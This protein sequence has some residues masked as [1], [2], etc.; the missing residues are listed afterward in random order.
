MWYLISIAFLSGS[1]RSERNSHEAQE[2][3]LAQG[4]PDI[5]Q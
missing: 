1:W 5:M 2:H 3:A 4:H